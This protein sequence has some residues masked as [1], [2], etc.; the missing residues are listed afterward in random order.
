M[1]GSEDFSRN[2][3]APL[4]TSPVAIAPP[5]Q[6][7][8]RQDSG[9][10][11]RARSQTISDDIPRPAG[12][13]DTH[14]GKMLALPI[15][16]VRPVD[17]NWQREPGY[18]G[19]NP[20][21][22]RGE[23]GLLP[24]SWGEGKEFLNAMTWREPLR[25]LP[26]QKRA[27]CRINGKMQQLPQQISDHIVSDM[28]ELRTQYAKAVLDGHACEESRLEGTRLPAV[29]QSRSDTLPAQQPEAH[30]DA[31]K[32]ED[33]PDDAE[34]TPDRHSESAHNGQDSGYCSGETNSTLR[35]PRENRQDVLMVR[36][37]KGAI[38]KR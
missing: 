14:S 6:R 38:E 9:T 20:I 22:L 28:S 11:E 30:N 4:R 37:D 10:R 25:R 27:G 18:L 5:F 21:T 8:S 32:W 24:G 33:V 13:S 31:A 16:T 15:P 12:L 23:T 3:Q 17:V 1:L 29:I 2:H 26:G 36:F 34:D 7:Q 35:T 19:I